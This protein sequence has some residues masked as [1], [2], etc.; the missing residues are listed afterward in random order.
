MI[1]NAHNMKTIVCLISRQPMANLLPV[2]MYRPEKVFLLGT[3]EE[4]SA[5][6]HLKVLCEEKKIKTVL[7]DDIFPY[8]DVK[9]L[10]ILSL[11]IRDNP[12]GIYLNV[13][14]GTKLMAISAY[15]FF[16]KHQKPVFYCNTN[17]NSIIHLLPEKRS[18]PLKA[19]ISIEDYLAVYGY[20]IVDAK[21]FAAEIGV[22]K[23]LEWLLPDK[24]ESFIPFADK[25]RQ[26]VKL[27]ELRLTRRFGDFQFEKHFDI[28]RVKHFPSDTIL[29]VS[30]DFFH[31]KWFE[32]AAEKIIRN[33]LCCNVKSGVKI[34][35][36]KGIQNEIDILLVYKH[37]LYLFSCKSG[38]ID[39]AG[40]KEHL[41]ELEVLRTL[42]GGTFGKA[43]FIYASQIPEILENRAN[44]FKIKPIPIN[45]LEKKISDE[46]KE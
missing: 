38:K 28:A 10:D 43:F 45:Q 1:T 8:D 5:G 30:A 39:K 19:D 31:G 3:K 24:L 32:A 11:I 16:L 44:E 22:S 20:S 4:I 35:S 40:M 29:K 33:E 46:I 26:G 25:V 9:L 14:G 34:V 13:T 27:N 18:V 42:T 37:Q 15:E 21:N 41:A 23:F 12:E 6:Y 36:S 2:L 7:Y 17:D